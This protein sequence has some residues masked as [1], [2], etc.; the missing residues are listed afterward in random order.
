MNEEAVARKHMLSDLSYIDGLEVHLD[1]GGTT[2][3]IAMPKLQ[4][5]QH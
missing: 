4:R 3:A 2:S 1:E 5:L